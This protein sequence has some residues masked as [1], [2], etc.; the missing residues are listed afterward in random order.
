MRFLFDRNVS[1]HLPRGL[2]HFC[3]DHLP[4]PPA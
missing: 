1:V 2:H 4:S 3:R